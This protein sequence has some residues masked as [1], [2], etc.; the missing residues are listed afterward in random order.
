ML[1]QV[2]WSINGLHIYSWQKTNF[3]QHTFYVEPSPSTLDLQ[4]LVDPTTPSEASITQARS[5]PMNYKKKFISV[6]KVKSSGRRL[7]YSRK[8]LLE[9]L[10]W[11]AKAARKT[12]LRSEKEII[13]PVTKTL[14]NLGNDLKS[15]RHPL[16]EVVEP[17]L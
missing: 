9:V 13:L 11:S 17:L 15:L 16:H 3:P 7:H 12:N 8:S 6:K 5:Q 4:K 2:N 10:T 14:H 1:T